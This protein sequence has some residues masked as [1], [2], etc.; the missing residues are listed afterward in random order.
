MFAANA[1][2]PAMTRGRR[3][4]MLPSEMKLLSPPT[5]RKTTVYQRRGA[6]ATAFKR[7]Q[8]LP[9]QLAK[10]PSPKKASPKPA[11]KSTENKK[12]MPRIMRPRS[13]STA[14]TSQ[15][16]NDSVN[17]PKLASPKP[18][19][20]VSL[21]T[22][23]RSTRRTRMSIAT[24]A[25]RSQSL[26]KTPA[27]TDVTDLSQ[28]QEPSAEKNQLEVLKLHTPSPSGKTPVTKTS[29]SMTKIKSPLTKVKTPLMRVT[30]GQALNGSARVTPINK[31]LERVKSAGVESHKKVHIVT[32]ASD[33]DSHKV[34]RKTPS[35]SKTP[36][37]VVVAQ[38]T[39]GDTPPKAA[40]ILGKTPSVRKSTIKPKNL[41]SM[42]SASDTL[43]SP[44]TSTPV[45]LRK[46]RADFTL[47]MSAIRQ[48]KKRVL[49]KTANVTL[50]EEVDP[51]EVTADLSVARAQDVRPRGFWGWCT[52]L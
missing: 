45:S 16:V 26:A 20:P 18:T 11:K 30:P 2:S 31:M 23:R 40:R 44:K 3:A 34:Y 35:R 49:E 51:A 5:R 21:S 39:Q 9:R 15:K 38:A 33:S 24:P 37:N 47:P 28:P 7:P 6:T 29:R 4:T 1:T 13:R 17:S 8:P 14:N 19:T 27:A 42:V 46:R 43:V 50:E 32:G 48:S 10:K 36:I 25:N 22:S 52:I 41:E 12:L